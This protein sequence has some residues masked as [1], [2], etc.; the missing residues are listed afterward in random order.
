[1]YIL[2][3]GNESFSPDEL[4]DITWRDDQGTEV[5]PVLWVDDVMVNQMRKL[6]V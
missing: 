2:T 4:T 3:S 5:K 6:E 1:M